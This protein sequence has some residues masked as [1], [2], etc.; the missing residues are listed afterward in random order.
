MNALKPEEILLEKSGEHRWV[1]HKARQK[2][3]KLSKKAC[4]RIY[5]NK[6]TACFVRKTRTAIEVSLG[7]YRRTLIPAGPISTVAFGVFFAEHLGL[8]NV[9][10]ILS[11][12]FAHVVESKMMAV[13]QIKVPRGSFLA[14]S[15]GEGEYCEN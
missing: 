10:W 11:L 13:E 1:V 7:P 5:R 8:R 14:R 6:T 12:T 9:T 2:K 3:N 4:Y 15:R